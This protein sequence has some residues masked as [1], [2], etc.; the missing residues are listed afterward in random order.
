[1][2]EAETKSAHTPGPWDASL[3]HLDGGWLHIYG[4]DG[5]HVFHG[6]RSDAEHMANARLIAAAPDAIAA[7]KLALA[8]LDEADAFD[9][10][11]RMRFNRAKTALRAAISRAEA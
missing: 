2:T 3:A 9:L 11:Q 7:A 4:P 10:D 8:A 5:K 6:D 1:M